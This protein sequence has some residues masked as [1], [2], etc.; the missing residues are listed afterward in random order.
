[1][2]LNLGDLNLREVFLIALM[3]WGLFVPA[4]GT[5]LLL[6][7]QARKLDEREILRWQGNWE[8]RRRRPRAIRDFATVFMKGAKRIRFA[9]H[10]CGGLVLV[11]LA[12]LSLTL[13][14]IFGTQAH[15][16]LEQREVVTS[17]WLVAV[18]DIGILLPAYLSAKVISRGLRSVG[19][20]VLLIAANL[21]AKEPST[22]FRIE[23]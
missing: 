6:R 1:M 7:Y 16:L 21:E 12:F 23:A 3:G 15:H 5:F 4:I 14:T 10:L 9:S 2:P 19:E 18:F 17:L 20:K 8:R 11:G 13:L 22:R